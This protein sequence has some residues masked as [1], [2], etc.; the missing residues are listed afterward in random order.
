M[1]ITGNIAMLELER[2]NGA[3][4][5]TLVWDEKSLVLIDTG[6][7]GQTDELVSSIEAEGFRAEDITHIILTHQDIDHIGCLPDILRLAPSAQVIAQAEEAP[8]I[9]GRKTPIKL[10]ALEAAYDSLPEQMKQFYATLRDG[11]ANRRVAVSQTVESGTVLPI[12]GGIEVVHTP[13][14]TPGHI[15]LYLRQAKIMVAGDAANIKND[16]ITG[17]NPQHTQDMAQGLESLEKLN[18]YFC[19]GAIAYHCGLLLLDGAA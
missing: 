4:Y 10:A 16:R 15:A 3:I 2:P 18:A 5:P 11:F 17:P 8:Y 6:F 9:D 7:P 1:K 14:H 19:R 13:G 12:G